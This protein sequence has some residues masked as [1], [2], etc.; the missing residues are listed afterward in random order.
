MI[1]KK[2]TILLLKGRT[3]N[4]CYRLR[5]DQYRD[6]IDEPKGYRCRYRK[7]PK[8]GVCED[9]KGHFAYIPESEIWIENDGEQKRNNLT[10]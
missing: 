2:E 1:S 9:F 8:I 7:P 10:T 3:C 4:S 6:Y 5:A